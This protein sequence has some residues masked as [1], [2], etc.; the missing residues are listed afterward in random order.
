MNGRKSKLIRK[1]A[2]KFWK[3]K[4]G[5]VP[6]KKIQKRFKALYKEGQIS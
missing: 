4:N 2:F 6:L 1:E 5:T 3:A